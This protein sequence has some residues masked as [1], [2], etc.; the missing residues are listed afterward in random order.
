[1]EEDTNLISTIPYTTIDVTSTSIGALRIIE[2]NNRVTSARNQKTCANPPVG[3]K[4]PRIQPETSP[5]I[6]PPQT[7]T[8]NWKDGS[9]HSLAETHSAT[10]LGVILFC[11]PQEE[12][13]CP[14]VDRTISR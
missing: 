6:P 13:S 12:A 4:Q 2:N 7:Q 5:Q 14:E 11:N 8:S 3:I 9:V 1:V 10:E